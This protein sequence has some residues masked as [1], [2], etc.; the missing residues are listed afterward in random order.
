HLAVDAGGL[1]VA[2]A[3]V[4]DA[5]GVRER[6]YAGGGQPAD[7]RRRGGQRTAGVGQRGGRVRDRAGRGHGQLE[8]RRRELELRALVGRRLDDLGGTREQVERLG[9]EQHQLLLQP[10]GQRL[11]SVEGGAE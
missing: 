11:G 9:V 2:D 6:M 4:Q 3:A 5:D 1:V 8:L 10:Q 7:G